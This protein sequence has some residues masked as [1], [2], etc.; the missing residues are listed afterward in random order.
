MSNCRWQP[1]HVEL[2]LELHVP[3]VGPLGAGG[4]RRPGEV[5]L[6]L[7]HR[8]LLPQ[9]EFLPPQVRSLGP[10]VAGGLVVQGRVERLRLLEHDGH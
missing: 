9:G 1:V 2:R 5:A 3:G 6:R 8:L 7:H 4:H 10:V